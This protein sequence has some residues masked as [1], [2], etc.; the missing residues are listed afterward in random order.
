MTDTLSLARSRHIALKSIRA[1]RPAGTTCAGQ[2]LDAAYQA[3]RLMAR[4]SP[5]ALEFEKR[6]LKEIEYLNFRDG[7]TYEQGLFGDVSA[8]RD[9]KEVV[10]AALEKRSPNCSGD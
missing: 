10:N 6:S 1:A 8:Y 2:L 5:V 3:A 9:A 7:Y 4:H